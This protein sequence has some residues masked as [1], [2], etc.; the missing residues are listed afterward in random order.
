MKKLISII[1]IITFSL[2]FHIT[3]DA[4]ENHKWNLNLILNDGNQINIAIDN[5]LLVEASDGQIVIY[6]N[7]DTHKSYY[8][9]SDVKSI[10][11]SQRNNLFV[12]SPL[13]TPLI[14]FKQNTIE[15]TIPGQQTE[16]N[17]HSL[18]G[19]LFFSDRFADTINIDT[20]NYPKGIY[21]LTVNKYPTIK[22]IL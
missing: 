6:K 14:N 13:C 21:L 15:V 1:S 8:E 9:L 12:E 4:D 5:S 3:S 2:I 16:V 7:S 10:K 11:Y 19:S 20:S 22:I 18:E 17:I